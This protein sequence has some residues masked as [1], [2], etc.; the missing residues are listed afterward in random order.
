MATRIY[1]ALLRL[2]PASFRE[3][4]GSEML[5]LFREG[6]EEARTPVAMGMRY[7]TTFGDGSPFIAGDACV[8]NGVLY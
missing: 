2:L 1:R 7:A 4:N 8:G 3:R 6:R 5:R